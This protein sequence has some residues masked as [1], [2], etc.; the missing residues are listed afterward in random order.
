[1]RFVAGE[2]HLGVGYGDV[3]GEVCDALRRGQEGMRAGARG[4]GR[5]CATAAEGSGLAVKK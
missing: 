2:G 1:M 5:D 4:V 3:F